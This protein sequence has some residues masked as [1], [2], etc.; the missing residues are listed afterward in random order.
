MARAD[1]LLSYLS[2]PTLLLLALFAYALWTYTSSRR[3]AHIPGPWY[4]NYTSLPLLTWIT[5]GTAWSHY[6]ELCKTYGPLVR[7]A[8]DH[9]ITGSATQWKKMYAARNGYPRSDWFNAMRFTPG[10]DNTLS[11]RDE[12]AHA[13]MRMKLAGGYGG[14]ENP[15]LEE[16]IDEQVLALVRLIERKYLS[17]SK[18]GV[19]KP[20]DLARKSHFFTLDVIS[21]LAFG[22]CFG[23]LKDDN[24]NFG[25]LHET[26]KS[27]TLINLMAVLPNLY[28]FL[29]KSQLLKMLGPSDRDDLGLGRTFKIASNI[30]AKRFGGKSSSETRADEKPSQD[31]KDMMGS[32]L[33]HGLTSEQ[34]ESEV[35]LQIL[36][37]SDT[38]A[39]AVR[40]VLLNVLSSPAVYEKLLNE[41][42]GTEIAGEVISDPV[43]RMMKYLQACIKEGL[44]I[45]PPVSGLFSH[46]V[47]AGGGTI[48]GLYVP[49]GTRIGWS[50]YAMTRDKTLFGPDESCFRPERWLLTADGGDCEDSAKLREMEQNNEVI[51]GYGRFKC[52]GQ[53]VALIELNKIFVELLRRFVIK[54]C[55]SKQP[56]EQ[57]FQIGIWVQTGMWVRVSRRDQ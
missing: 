47:P 13:E 8:P 1:S 22:E 52:L 33:R 3:L 35:V 31:R 46:E 7:I 12:K 50:T 42:D 4:T 37:G 45:S 29:E 17:D 25:Y 20:M 49:G 41:I 38:T 6:G 40:S 43:A 51:F 2:I 15:D 28:S 26:E 57:D 23:D 48:D 9:L 16:R 11:M 53:A 56:L 10:K 19:Y 54:I 36:A 34:V 55:N 44:R 30:V 24:D 21:S 32:F 5:R 39:T 14:K 27:I 18:R